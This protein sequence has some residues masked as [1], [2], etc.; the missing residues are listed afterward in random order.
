MS[1]NKPIYNCPGEDKAAGQAPA[2]SDRRAVEAAATWADSALPAIDARAW[3]A[4]KRGRP[5]RAQR[6]A[7]ARLCLKSIRVGFSAAPPRREARAAGRPP[8]S[9]QQEPAE[10]LYLG[11]APD[12]L[13][14]QRCPKALTTEGD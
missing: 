6:A 3:C 2:A 7:A 11:E 8:A 12:P 13:R 10:D 9:A 5:R 4:R 14:H 1:C